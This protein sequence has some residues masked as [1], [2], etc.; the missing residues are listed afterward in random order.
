MF[1]AMQT[2]KEIGFEGPFMMDHTPQ[3]AQQ[4]A[5]WAGRAYAVGYIRGLIQSVYR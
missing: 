5:G 4:Q 3:F 2:Y 1:K